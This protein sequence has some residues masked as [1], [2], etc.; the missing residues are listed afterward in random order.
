[1]A[2][3]DY[4]MGIATKLVYFDSA[5]IDPLFPMWAAGTSRKV[6][7][8]KCL[9]NLVDLGK[10]EKRKTHHCLPGSKG[11]YGDH[12]RELTASLVR[13]LVSYPDSLVFREHFIEAA[14]LRPDALVL[15]RN[16]A[17]GCLV[18]FEQCNEERSEYFATKLEKLKAWEGAKE[19]LSQLFKYRIPSFSV[20]R[21]DE[22]TRFME[23]L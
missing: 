21:S 10:L 18:W 22:L 11:D 2:H 23:A 13:I 19:Y 6:N 9:K 4:A 15:I 5:V 12:A 16:Q 17:R 1:M 20:V 7:I 3:E 14:A 8:G